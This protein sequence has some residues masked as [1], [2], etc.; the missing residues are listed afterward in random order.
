MGGTF[1]EWE[2][3]RA[4]VPQGAV[5]APSLYNIYAADI[6]MRQ[7][8]EISQFADDITVSTSNRNNN[9]AVSNLQ[10]CVRI[11]DLESWLYKRK[12]KINTAAISI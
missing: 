12:I 5:L 3:I 7:E 1:S 2:P 9:Y 10:R 4:G 8:I 11:S 6:H